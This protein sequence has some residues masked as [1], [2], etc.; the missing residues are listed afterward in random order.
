MKILFL[1]L[2]CLII[3][4][5]AFVPSSIADETVQETK[6]V[7]TKPLLIKPILIKPVLIRPIAP[8]E[9]LKPIGNCSAEDKEQYKNTVI[10][11]KKARASFMKMKKQYE[12]LEQS[13]SASNTEINQ[14]KD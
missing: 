6:P 3:D 11:Y 8:R 13:L 12:K 2:C 14:S 4:H 10:Q 9:P 5:T 1:F 7:L